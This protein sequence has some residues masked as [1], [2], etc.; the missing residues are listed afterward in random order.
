MSTLSPDSLRPLLL[1]LI[2]ALPRA[3]ETLEDHEF[4]THRDL[5]RRERAELAL[6]AR[7]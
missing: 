3:Y 7:E 5:P 1:D 2:Y 4:S 6:E